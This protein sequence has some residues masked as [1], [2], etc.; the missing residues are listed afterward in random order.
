MIGCRW[1]FNCWMKPQQNLVFK[2]KA[3]FKFENSRFSFS[4]GFKAFC[5]IC[6][7]IDFE[8]ASLI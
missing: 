4:R 7:Q 8:K 1:R 3:K 5:S 6:I 2:S